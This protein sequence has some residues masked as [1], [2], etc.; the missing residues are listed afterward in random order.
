MNI[1][2]TGKRVY[3]REVKLEDAPFMYD[4]MNQQA[5]LAFIGDR[6]ITSLDKAKDYIESGPMLSY[7]VHGFGLYLLIVK[8]SDKP[9]GACGLLK[10]TY[11]DAP[12]LGF[13]ISERYCRQGFG[14]EASTL[15]LKAAKTLTNA[16]LIYASVNKANVGSCNLLKKLG[17]NLHPPAALKSLGSEADDLLLYAKNIKQHSQ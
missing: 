2:A 15:V 17:F 1:I 9:V 10:R 16:N 3:L 13:A 5:W 14:Y 12:D 7:R 6:G 4:L 8:G 11:L